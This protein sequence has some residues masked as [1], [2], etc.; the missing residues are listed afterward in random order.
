MIGES[1]VGKTTIINGIAYEIMTG[2]EHK[3]LKN[4]RVVSIDVGL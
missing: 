1:G 3:T 2:T 4:K